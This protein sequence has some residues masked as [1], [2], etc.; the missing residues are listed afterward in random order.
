MKIYNKVVIDI[1][2]GETIFEDSFEYDGEVAQCKSKGG[3]SSGDSTTT[4][5]YAPYI[6]TRHQEFLN[7]TAA[8]RQY[9]IGSAGGVTM[10]IGSALSIPGWDGTMLDYNYRRLLASGDTED[11][12]LIHD[13][14][15]IDYTF[16]ETELAFFGTGYTI[17][18]FPTLYDMYGKFM[19]GLDID[20]LF[21]Q[22][23]EDTVN[24]PEV[25]DLVA[26]EGALIEDDVIEA[27]TAIE[28]GMRDINSVQA[29]TFV[30]ARAIPRDTKVKVLEK[31]RSELKYRL[32]PVATDRWKTH[33]EWNKTVIM[34]YAE[35]M[36]LYYSVKMDVNDANYNMVVKHDLWPFTVLD[37]ER[38]NIGALQGATKTTS[39][40]AGSSTAQKAIS[41]ALSGASMGAVAGAA[42]GAKYG[43]WYGAAIGGFLGLAG[44]F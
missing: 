39:E 40:V 29:S 3:S 5:R 43:G 20:T 22:M 8:H 16:I 11:S 9:L 6:E 41:G 42:T 4:V 31:F 38:A 35:V 24:S 13:S 25:N 28:V 19:A 18:S 21:S 34:T 37:Y 14:P 36:K 17:A 7:T 2:S 15:Y 1:S 26:A 12:A 33:L 27:V 32:I 10:P 44:A 30:V 23:F